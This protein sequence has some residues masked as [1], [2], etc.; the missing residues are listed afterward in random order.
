MKE[1]NP[2]VYLST[3]IA[4]CSEARELEDELIG[5][6]IEVE[7]PCHI[8]PSEIPP[9]D[10]QRVVSSECYKMINRSDAVVLLISGGSGTVGR[11]CSAEVGYTVAQEKPIFAYG[12]EEALGNLL[13]VDDGQRFM[14][15]GQI[16][17]LKAIGTSEELAEEI[18]HFHSRLK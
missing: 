18:W 12:K 5:Q 8:M 10:R 6:G 16:E 17:E 3:R 11:D 13:K 7:N 1:D 9:A 14:L 15:T 4:W 2:R